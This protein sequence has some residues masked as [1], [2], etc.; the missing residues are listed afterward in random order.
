M[1]S[2]RAILIDIEKNRLD[3]SKKHT[4]LNKE[5]HLMNHDE[6][7]RRQLVVA[8]SSP[9]LVEV[10]SSDVV[11][12]SIQAVIEELAPTVVQEE[13]IVEAPVVEEIKLVAIEPIVEEIEQVV[14]EAVVVPEEQSVIEEVPTEEPKQQKRRGRKFST[15][16]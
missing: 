8:V 5:G 10:I 11:E 2:S 15:H 9:A 6:A 12:D 3:A 14:E 16:A 4:T 13:I 7:L 1:P